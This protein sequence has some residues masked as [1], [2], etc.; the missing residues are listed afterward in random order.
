M[1]YRICRRITIYT[2]SSLRHRFTA[3]L[4]TELLKTSFR[5]PHK[6]LN[7]YVKAYCG[8]I[9]SDGLD[10]VNKEED[11]RLEEGA[12]LPFNF[13]KIYEGTCSNTY[14]P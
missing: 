8:F 1:R 2:E 11:V 14:L 3:S 13:T 9:P 4:L 7:E 6:I 5:S 12:I 10:F